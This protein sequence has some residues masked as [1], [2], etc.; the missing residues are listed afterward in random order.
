MKNALGKLKSLENL[1][2]GYTPVRSSG[3]P[4][5]FDLEKLKV[6]DLSGCTIVTDKWIKQLEARNPKILIAL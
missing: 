2:L 5:L 6:L 4:Y 3:L 1:Y